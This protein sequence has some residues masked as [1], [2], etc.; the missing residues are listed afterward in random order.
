[1]Q[2]TLSGL[3]E[4]FVRHRG[5]SPVQRVGC[6]TQKNVGQARTARLT[7]NRC[8]TEGNNLW[9]HS[10]AAAVVYIAQWHTKHLLYVP[11]TVK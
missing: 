4:A 1:M 7:G 8:T 10:P 2:S 6:I 9:T 5:T 11:G 3:S